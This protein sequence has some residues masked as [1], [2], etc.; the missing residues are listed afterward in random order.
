MLR[1]VEMSGREHMAAEEAIEEARIHVSRGACERGRR[2][3]CDARHKARVHGQKGRGAVAHTLFIEYVSEVLYLVDRDGHR[4]AVT[5]DVHTKKF[6]EFT[7]VFEF[8]S[9]A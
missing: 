2:G 1:A 6:V 9:L 7:Q 8:E 3:R 5:G 4:D